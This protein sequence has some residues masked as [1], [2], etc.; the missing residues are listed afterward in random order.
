MHWGGW[1]VFVGAV[2]AK[3]TVQQ[4]GDP[5]GGL[6][7][8]VVEGVPA[9]EAIQQTLAG[10]RRH[11]G[12]DVAFVAEFCDGQRV[13]RYLDAAAGADEIIHVGD[14]D[15]LDA[16][17]CERVLD[18]RLPEVIPDAQVLPAARSLAVTGALPV[19]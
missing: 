10:F 16:S 2:V 14:A 11:F 7:L 19:G 1:E 3:E 18:G 9:A 12:L 6:P 13:F 17:Y 4:R 15:P 8:R 5:L